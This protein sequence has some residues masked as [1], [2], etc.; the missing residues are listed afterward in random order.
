M[1]VGVESAPRRRPTVE[2]SEPP[3]VA[4]PSGDPGF[5]LVVRRHPQAA[6]VTPVAP[7]SA[8]GP[9]HRDE[10]RAQSRATG[11]SVQTRHVQD[12]HQ[13]DGREDRPS[14]DERGA[15]GRAGPGPARGRRT[16]PP[17]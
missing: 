7:R 14:G 4:A 9:P 6:T 13:S 2:L 8:G 1:I 10:H 3:G 17:T 12:R 11:A 5:D 16:T 15:R